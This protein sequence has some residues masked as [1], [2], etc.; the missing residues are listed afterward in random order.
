MQLGTGIHETG[1]LAG[2]T[3]WRGP[4]PAVE[5]PLSIKD[6]ESG[7]AQQGALCRL[8]L[9]IG[10]SLPPE[11]RSLLRGDPRLH[12]RLQEGVDIGGRARLVHIVRF[13]HARN[14]LVA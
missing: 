13:N 7:A 1:L 9:R 10:A 11:R 3:M 4:D 6:T 8:P 5:A 2:N 14:D 12:K